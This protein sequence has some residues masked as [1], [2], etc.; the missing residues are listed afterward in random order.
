MLH[1]VQFRTDFKAEDGGP[2]V[3]SLIDCRLV[4]ALD[5]FSK[6]L[7]EQGIVEVFFSS[8]YRPPPKG[9][10]ETAPGRRHGGGLAIDVHRFKSAE[11]G[12]LS[13]E[14]D[15]HGRLGARVCGSSARPP[16]PAAKSSSLLRKLVCTAAEQHL[17]QSILTP[18]YDRP[19]RNHFHLEL[20]PEVRWFIVS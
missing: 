15:F 16:L 5:D 12:W 13:V 7:H 14:K 19:H 18:N 2:S 6:T 1:D 17:F 20:T 11:L 3:Y 10:D 9:T 4:L 8:A